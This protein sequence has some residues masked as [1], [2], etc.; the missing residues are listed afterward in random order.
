MVHISNA[1]ENWAWTMWKPAASLCIPCRWQGYK[2]LSHH[3]SGAWYTLAEYHLGSKGKIIPGTL[4]WNVGIWT[5]CST[6]L[7]PVSVLYTGCNTAS[8]RPN[9][10]NVRAWP[11]PMPF[12]LAQVSLPAFYQTKVNDL[13]SD[14]PK[15]G[16]L[17]ASIV[18]KEI[19]WHIQA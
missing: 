9:P 7:A 6:M 12:P 15:S 14:P 16:I 10:S 5:Y 11:R 8:L 17:A 19:L 4:I 1:H 2:Y 18:R 13:G 3:L